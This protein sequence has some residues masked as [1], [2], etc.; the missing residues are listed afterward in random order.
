M[1]NCQTVAYR[2]V[3]TT[4]TFLVIQAFFCHSKWLHPC[5]NSAK[6][7]IL[8]CLIFARSVCKLKF[9]SHW[10]L[11]TEVCVN[12]SD[13][14]FWWMKDTFVHQVLTFTVIRTNVP[15]FSGMSLWHS[16]RTSMTILFKQE[17]TTWFRINAA[18]LFTPWVFEFLCN[19]FHAVIEKFLQR[20]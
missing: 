10:R 11:L 2:L 15:F 4:I 1:S 12:K 13:P 3:I 5:T 8:S 9:D 16:A 14:L 18:H 7:L 17:S 20:G 6:H 19:N